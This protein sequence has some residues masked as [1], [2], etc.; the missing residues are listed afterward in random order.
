MGV[1][2]DFYPG[3][4]SVNDIDA[5]HFLEEVWSADFLPVGMG[6]TAETMPVAAGDGDLRF[7]Y[8]MGEDVVNSD[9]SSSRG[10]KELENLDF[11]VVQEIFMTD[12]ADMADLVLPA[13]AWA[14][15]DGSFTSSE[16]RVQWVSRAIDPPGEA[17]SDLWTILEVAKRLGL[18]F[19]Y[20]GPEE[21]LA[22]IGRVVPSY[23]GISRERAEARGG[24]IW[25]CPRPNHPGTPILHQEEF[26]AP[27]GRARIVSVDYHPPAE[28]SSLDYPLLLT[29]GRVALHYNAGSMTRRS[30]S[31]MRRAPELF[32]E[33]NPDDADRWSI[34]D[35][36]LVEVNTRRG[37]AW[38]RARVTTRQERGVLF[39]PFHFPDTNRLTSDVIDPESRIP[40]FKVAAC[41][42]GKMKGV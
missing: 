17:R 38:A 25:P 3:S 39:M 32:V 7:L 20:A 6:M 21:V 37:R 29:T 1:L 40:E 41:R 4:R 19:D 24:V 23:A 9:S 34:I 15:K 22:E 28:E 16:R 33:V 12:T 8:V 30:F 26:S 35:G 11:M 18:G 14:E 31:L 5:V 27:A 2:A 10:R 13:A 36:D 42:I